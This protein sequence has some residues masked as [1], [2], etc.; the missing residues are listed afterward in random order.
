MAQPW[1]GVLH[2]SGNATITR[3]RA[4]IVRLRD[5][6]DGARTHR[7]TSASVKSS[8]TCANSS[9]FCMRHDTNKTTR[10]TPH[11]EC[12]TTGTAQDG[13]FSTG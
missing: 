8:S 6:D 3:A 1:R 7:S 5:C 12:P 10:L 9:S 4:Q 13:P 11:S 2:R